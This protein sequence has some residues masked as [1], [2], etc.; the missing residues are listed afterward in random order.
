MGASL[1]QPAFSGGVVSDQLLG[2]SD[3]QKYATGLRQCENAVI[4]RYGTIENRAGTEFVG[5]IAN[6]DNPARLVPFIVS[7]ET[8]YVLEF[9]YSDAGLIGTHIRPWLN[10]SLV[11]V[12]GAAAWDIGTPYHNGDLVTYSGI[13]YRA[14]GDSTGQIPPA[15]PGVWDP[16]EGDVLDIYAASVTLDSF[17]V[18][19]Y[20]QQNDIMTLVAQAWYPS[21]L[22]R[23]S[24]TDWALQAFVVSTGILAPTNVTVTAG[25]PFTPG[26]A[27]VVTAI[28]GNALLAKDYYIVVAGLTPDPGPNYKF[29]SD[30]AASTV[31]GADAGN[32]V[33]LTWT[34]A[35]PGPGFTVTNYSV[36]KL[37]GTQYRLVITV[38]GTAYSD[39][40]SITPTVV[41]ETG[42]DNITT[43]I[44]AVTSV[45]G[46]GVES[47]ISSPDD[48]TGLFI[49]SAHP[50][51]VGWTGA[52]GAASYRVYR[53]LS[54]VY[55]F[56][57]SAAGT[58][59]NDTGITPDVSIQPPQ[60][61]PD[62]FSTSD[63]YPAVVGVY[64][65]RLAFA[66]TVNEPQTLVFS[67]TAVFTDFTIST[68]VRANDAITI[69]L[70]GRQKQSIRALIDLGKLIIHT[71]NA[72][73]VAPGNSAGALSPV[74]GDSVVAQG[75]AGSG[76]VVPVVIGNTDLF[77]QAGATRL[78]DLRYEVQSFAFTG[79]DLTKYAN[80]LFS[81]RT[82]VDMAWQKLPQSV[83]WCILDNGQMASLTY[84]REDDMWAWALHSS[85][86]GAFENVCVV[87]E[88]SQFVAYFVVRRVIDGST[89]RYIERLA[90]RDCLDTV[91]YSD[92]IFADCSLTY[93]G[94][95]TDASSIAVT[96]SGWTPSD[97]LTI[98]ASAPKF[99]AGDLG[100]QVVL[101][102]ISATTGLVTDYVSLNVLEYVSPTVVRGQPLRNV[103]VWAQAAA[104]TTWG[105]A[106]DEFSGID[107]L[108]GQSLA[109]LADG[110]VAAD[111]LD[112]GYPLVTV[113]GGAFTLP[114]PA[115]VVT[116]GLPIQ[117][118]I[119]TLPAENAQGETIINKR[120]Q[121]RE[122]CPVFFNSRGG[123]FG[124]DAEHLKT[125]KQPKNS[126][127]GYPVAPFTGP[128]RIPIQGSSQDTGQV[129]VRLTNPVPFSMSAIVTTVEVGN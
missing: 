21:Q 34:A 54:G 75:S 105:L 20:V 25:R 112:S 13:V 62:L 80:G 46:L 11:D 118:D 24:N 115:L 76:T 5:E 9:S 40:A 109:I 100:N 53:Q 122:C 61:L 2:R 126:A 102:R 81:G 104:I 60:T 124:Q 90:N 7:Q 43:Y 71:S 1:K 70:A 83:V 66:N 57:G 65:Q 116:A 8:S 77:L 36:Y 56:V 107:H 55:A 19:Q 92:A 123:L 35:N 87:T 74:D 69:T 42:S 110:N 114:T 38:S 15:F 95:S 72:E 84:I 48:A 23:Y 18:L 4:T 52:S 103:P 85:A 129:C 14:F 128:A 79:K 32:P 50:N 39:D 30:A 86:N 33:A 98:A 96:G 17:P 3:V 59:F 93:D 22:L 68:P 113:S 37:V 88:G 31:G 125:W 117:M 58:S 108:E 121:V 106:T 73:Y 101:Q 99:D 97:L 6:S 94:R 91:F 41:L 64:Q 10:G 51:I 82:I 111:P 12:A 27:S 44:Y 67:R 49:D 89:K 127:L 120:V 47:L 78:N 16:Q 63:D 45:N 119:Q 29:S 26:G 28:G